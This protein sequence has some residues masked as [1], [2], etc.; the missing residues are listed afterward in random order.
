MHRG[1]RP[2]LPDAGVQRV[3]PGPVEGA[4]VP[5]PRGSDRDP[6]R[7]GAADQP[8]YEQQPGIEHRGRVRPLHVLEEGGVDRA[9]RVVEREED[10]ATTGADGRGL[11][12]DLHAGD[13]YLGTVALVEQRP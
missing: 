10:H 11:G 3:V 8:P 6:T 9:S 7:P 2:G 4:E 13:Q 12:R 5:G 1:E